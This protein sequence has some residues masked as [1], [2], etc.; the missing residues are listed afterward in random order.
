MVL[1]QTALP[2][3]KLFNWVSATI[4]GWLLLISLCQHVNF[5]AAHTCEWGSKVPEVAGPPRY[6]RWSADGADVMYPGWQLGIRW[7]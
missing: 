3:A 6:F 5:N 4:L 7:N 2:V 1:L